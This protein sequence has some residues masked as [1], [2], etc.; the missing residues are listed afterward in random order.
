MGA[1]VTR[2][3][4]RY[5][6]WIGVAAG[7]LVLAWVL[8][9]FELARFARIVAGAE[10]WP[11]LVLPV[12][13]VV[14]QLVRAVKWRQIVYPVRAVGTL[15]LFW[16]IMAGYL[17]NLATPVRVSPLVRAWLVA[18]LEYLS[19]GTLLATITLDRVIDGLVFVGLTVLALAVA[20][21][22]G[23]TGGVRAGLAWGA[24]LSLGLFALVI[25]GLVALRPAF[26]GDN[27]PRWF[28]VVT[29]WLPAA[30][31]AP[32]ADFVRLFFAGVVWPAQ[33][34]RG[35]VIVGASVV[36]KL[37]AVSY[38]YWAGLA[39]G[40][41][42]SPQSYLFVMVF[43]GYLVVLAGTIRLPGGFI[44]G[45]VFVLEGFGVDVETALAM[46][47]VVGGASLLT[48]ATAGAMALWLQGVALGSVLASSQSHHDA[49]RE[50]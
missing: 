49:P 50:P 24:F 8:R 32:V 47:L 26:L 25:G 45:A 43:L 4:S 16:A 46:A 23:T 21:F 38:F 20:S 2:M 9:D 10:I 22:P 39:F 14:E 30:W 33:T 3:K 7:V 36:I 11:L 12:A 42:L 19:V 5:W 48:V 18:R 28:A 37:I 29:G 13:V 41:T 40:V 31:R 35:L 1:A 34:W 6:R 27:R 44:A 17:A 15:R